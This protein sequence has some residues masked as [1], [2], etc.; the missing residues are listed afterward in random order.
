[1]ELNYVYSESTVKPLS[2]EFSKNSV[3]LRRN[4]VKETRVDETDAETVWYTYE[5]ACLTP[6]EFNTY[7]GQLKAVNAIN[8]VNDSDN[9]ASILTGQ[10]TGDDNQLS[11][12]EAIADLYDLI[13]SKN[14]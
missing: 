9:I 1:M 3:Y 2:I 7:T 4:I 10:A 14:A 8:G 12:M 11:I 5:E 13:A 6:D